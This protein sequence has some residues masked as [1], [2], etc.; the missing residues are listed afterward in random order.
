M[1]LIRQNPLPLGVFWIDVFSPS[2]GRP[3]FAN[4][5]IPMATWLA[6]NVGSV[7]ITN[8]EIHSEG[9]FTENPFRFFYVFQVLKPPTN[10][11]F[12][13]LGFPTVVKLGAPDQILVGDTRVTSDDTVR[14]PPPEDA[15]ES[16]KAYLGNAGMLVAGSLAAFLGYKLLFDRE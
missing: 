12:V 7:K 11:P 9:T 15:V 13:E 2:A 3:D 10:F 5:E 8:R 14:K 1:T 6:S 16:L 4:G